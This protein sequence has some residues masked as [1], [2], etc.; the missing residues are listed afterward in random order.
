[1]LS[2]SDLG[3]LLAGALMNE[4]YPFS[5]ASPHILDSNE[6]MTLELLRERFRDARQVNHER[7]TKIPQLIEISPREASLLATIQEACLAEC[8]GNLVQIHILLEANDEGEVRALVDRL[9]AA[10]PAT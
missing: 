6:Q 8:R 5:F 3:I 9:R 2:D 4:D 10:G 1:M 7:Q